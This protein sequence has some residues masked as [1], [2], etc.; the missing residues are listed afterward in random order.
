MHCTSIVLLCFPLLFLY[1]TLVHGVI[2]NL[3]V[4]GIVELEI[5]NY[6]FRRKTVKD[7][8]IFANYGKTEGIE[9]M[10]VTLDPDSERM[11]LTGFLKRQ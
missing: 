5:N 2:I 11:I 10:R 9:K 3:K 4:D 1:S 8:K 7:L 6:N